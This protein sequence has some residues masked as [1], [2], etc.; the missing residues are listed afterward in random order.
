MKSYLGGSIPAFVANSVVL[1]AFDNL[2][3]LRCAFLR[4]KVV[5]TAERSKV[6]LVIENSRPEYN[7]YELGLIKKV[8]DKLK[9]IPDFKLKA[10]ESPDVHVKMAGALAK[11]LKTTSEERRANNNAMEELGMDT[12]SGATMRGSTVVDA[13]V[14][15]CC[16]WEVG[17]TRENIAYFFENG[18]LE[19]ETTVE[20]DHTF[21]KLSTFDLGI[22]RFSPREMVARCI[23]KWNEARDELTVVYKSVKH[24]NYPKRPKYVRTTSDALWCYKRLEPLHGIPQT[25]VTHTANMDL[26]GAMPAW[27][28]FSTSVT[29]LTVLRNMRLCFLRSHEI[30]VLNRLRMIET[31]KRCSSASD[32]SYT[33]EENK[34]LESGNDLE[35]QVRKN[36]KYRLKAP[37]GSYNELVVLAE[38][39]ELCGRSKV[40]IRATKEQVLA[41]FWNVAEKGSWTQADMSRT[42]LEKVNEHHQVVYQCLKSGL[43]G[44]VLD[45]RKKSWI[46]HMI[47]RK[48]SNSTFVLVA[49]PAEHVAKQESC[50]GS[51]RRRSFVNQ[52]AK[53]YAG[54]KHNSGGANAT[55]CSLQYI[56]VIKDISGGACR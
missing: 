12:N 20:N 51:G 40:E 3:A 36:K 10:F 47:W 49:K 30:E 21:V 31:V 39:K 44:G 18:G 38:G 15:E 8:V 32:Y 22:P 54:S 42:V 25:S 26:G 23:W 17:T 41:Y 16:A 56:V 7:K 6:A 46:N 14:E 35:S 4:D 43:S 5:D 19:S 50:D 27:A 24:S 28:I 1:R 52:L 34:V 13:T 53:V 45:V 2:N 29:A 55:T 33:E 11:D 37:P 48:A 9:T